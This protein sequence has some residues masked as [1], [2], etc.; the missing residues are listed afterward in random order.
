MPL[1]K[2]FTRQEILER[3]RRTIRE[4]KPIVGAGCSN[5]LIAKSAEAGGADLL[6]VYSTGRSRM[7]GLPTTSIGHANLVTLD[8]FDEIAN[9]VND[10]PVIGGAEAVDPTFMS[11]K[12]LNNAFRDKGYAGLINFPTIGMLH[13]RS[14]MREDAGLGFSREVEMVR[15][16][17]STDYFT[18]AYVFTVEQSCAMAQAG[19]DVL[20]PHVGWTVGGLV[21]RSPTS[22]PSFESSARDVQEMIDAAVAIH[23][24]CI[25][26]AH[27]GP[28]SSPEDTRRLYADTTA[29]G[30][31]GASSI[32]RIP[33]ERAVRDVVTAFKAVPMNKK[34]D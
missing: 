10:T 20:V 12:R 6:I 29:V 34:A 19:V 32:E 30:F 7:M 21:G 23:P 3:L 28:Y 8:M 2:S 24:D 22:A 9:V 4:G 1:E 25:C 13:E 16:A 18:M 5:G 17:R 27:G 14:A 11:L 33:V 15:L 26:L 31:V